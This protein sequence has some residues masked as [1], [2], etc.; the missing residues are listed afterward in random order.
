MRK[1][2]QQVTLKVTDITFQVK[3]DGTVEV[4]NVG[5]KDSKGEDNRVVKRMVQ[6]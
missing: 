2:L 1:Q 4:T 3:T 6:L 5:E